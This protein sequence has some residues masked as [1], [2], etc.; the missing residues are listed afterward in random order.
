MNFTFETENGTSL[1]A[2]CSPNQTQPEYYFNDTYKWTITRMDNPPFDCTLQ[3]V[4]VSSLNSGTYAC[5]GQ[6]PTDTPGEYRNVTSNFE[7]VEVIEH[8]VTLSPAVVTLD[9]TI[10]S[11]SGNLEI[12]Y[13][14][15]ITA[16]AAGIGLLTITFLIAW[17]VKRRGGGQGK[18]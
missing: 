2:T 7:S 9:P 1:V 18:I 6:L 4:N 17:A 10:K 8:D 14:I 11:S 13:I 3:L 16:I 15:V 5:I 12:I